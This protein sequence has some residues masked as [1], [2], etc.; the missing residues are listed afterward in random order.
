MASCSQ[1]LK[2]PTLDYLKKITDKKVK[3]K[4]CEAILAYHGGTSSMNNHVLSHHPDLCRINE[5]FE[6]SF[7]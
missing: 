3:C 2:S 1:H 5:L 6:Y 4:C 7:I